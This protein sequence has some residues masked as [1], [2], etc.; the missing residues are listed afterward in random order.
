MLFDILDVMYISPST[1]P[2]AAVDIDDYFDH[3]I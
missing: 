3:V 2:I 1:T